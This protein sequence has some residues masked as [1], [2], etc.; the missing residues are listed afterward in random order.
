[1]LD[2]NLA[3]VMLILNR[4]NV[5]AFERQYYNIVNA[6]KYVFHVSRG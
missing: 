2:S 1:M 6:L 3:A 5:D 4:R